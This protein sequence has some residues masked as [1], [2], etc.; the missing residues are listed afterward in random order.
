M[1]FDLTTIRLFIATAELGGITH[2]AD[3][4]H[5]VPAAASR[6][7]REFEAQLG[8]PLFDRLPHGMALTD[9]GRAMLAHARSLM[10]SVERMQGDAAAFLHGD[11][12]VVR[13]AACTSAVMQF[14]PSDISDCAARY[15]GIRIDLQELNSQG[16]MQ[17]IKR[18]IADL[19]VY[20]GS[21][22]QTSLPNDP[23]REDRLSVVTRSDHPFAGRER[24]GIADILDFDIIGLTE[25]ASISLTLARQ[26]AEADRALSMR[27]RV[28]SF[29]SMISMIAA[30]IGIGVM[31]EEI[32][33]TYAAGERFAH[34]PIDEKWAHRRFVICRQHDDALSGAARTVFDFLN[35]PR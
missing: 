17:T 6:R 7:I 32:A 5:L 12:G 21:L 20:E 10:H 26:A 15:P 35:R 34:V 1:R 8:L 25:G 30:G 28:G 31:P 9:A 2:A 29:D 27:I 4:L 23:Y 14:L 11:R 19:G 3:S 24:V 16:V 22:G 13:I 33:R 18:G